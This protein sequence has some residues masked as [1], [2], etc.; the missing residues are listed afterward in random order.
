MPKTL[1]T[2]IDV[3]IWSSFGAQTLTHCVSISDAIWADTI[4][5]NVR[6]ASTLGH[7]HAEFVFCSK[8][9]G[10][11]LEF[12]KNPHHAIPASLVCMLSETSSL[13]KT[14]PER[15][16]RPVPLMT[17]LSTPFQSYRLFSSSK[18][19]LLSLHVDKLDRNFTLPSVEDSP[20]QNTHPWAPFWYSRSLSSKVHTHKAFR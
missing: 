12:R 10:L 14:I 5:F 8:I 20:P 17:S 2:N 4:R 6:L 15:A 9:L 16:Q 7:D 1:D 3:N 13:H 18:G 19:T 11:C